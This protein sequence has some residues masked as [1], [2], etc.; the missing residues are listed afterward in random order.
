MK[1]ST[2]TIAYSINLVMAM[3]KLTT[4]II[5]TAIST[6]LAANESVPHLFSPSTPAKASEVNENFDYLNSRLNTLEENS[7]DGQL[8]LEIDCTNNPAALNEAYLQNNLIKDLKFFIKGS[9]Y[10]DIAVPRQNSE[11]FKVITNQVIS[12]VGIDNTAKL[13]DNDITGDVNLWATHGGGL[14]I[15]DMSIITS[16]SI[17]IAF[18]RNGHGT[19]TNVSI[20][21]TGGNVYAGVYA[22]EGA[23][24]YLVDTEINGFNIGVAGRNG[25]VIR[26]IGELAI[27]NV[28]I[29]MQLESSVFK[30]TGNINLSA[31]DLALDLNFNSAWQGWS[32]ALNITQGNINI[33][34]ASSL[35]TTQINATSAH[36]ELYHSTMGGENITANTLSANGSMVTISDS[37]FSGQV[38]SQHS[39]KVEMY[40]TSLTSVGVRQRGSFI[41]GGNSI[42]SVNVHGNSHAHFGQASLGDL[43]VNLGSTADLY[44]VSISG[45]VNVYTNSS[46][47]VNDSTFSNTAHLNTVD[48][49]HSLLFGGTTIAESQTSCHMGR[50]EIEGVDVNAFNNGCLNSGGYQEMI[51]VFKSSRGN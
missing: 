26:T 23:Q 41:F 37:S 40:N 20:T 45:N 21:A 27:T 22:Q 43:E 3:K 24:V 11:V 47:S 5:L 2:Y 29:G 44:Q 35:V 39:A 48:S 33:A 28:T 19:L 49:A 1:R 32:T 9:C 46:L 4:L 14:Y 8:E 18:S 42:D 30:G 34:N 10:G 12:L 38:V 50:L 16:G 13:I 31:T 15:T 51:D 6:P 7:G 25:A 17:P 36:I